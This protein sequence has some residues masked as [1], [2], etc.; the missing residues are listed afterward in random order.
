MDIS[1]ITNG[2]KSIERL[3]NYCKERNVTVEICEDTDTASGEFMCVLKKNIYYEDY[4]LHIQY[5]TLK[6]KKDS[7]KCDQIMFKYIITFDNYEFYT[8]INTNNYFVRRIP[9]HND[10]VFTIAEIIPGCCVGEIKPIEISLP[11]D[12]TLSRYHGYFLENKCV[13]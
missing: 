10:K 13:F 11:D 7:N 3:I 4:Y 1:V 12:N 5:V 2:N 9:L 6:F 8:G